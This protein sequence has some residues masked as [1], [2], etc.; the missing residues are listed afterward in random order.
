MADIVSSKPVKRNEPSEQKHPILDKWGLPAPTVEDIFPLM[1]AETELIA[2]T[3]DIYS[4]SEIQEA[5][6]GYISL[7]L[8]R[9]NEN[10][11][12]IMHLG[13]DEGRMKIRLVH[14]SP[15]VLTIEN[16][17][18]AQE[19]LDIKRLATTSTPNVAGDAP[20]QVDSAT[21][22]PM[23]Q[24]KRTSTSWFCYYHTVPV[25]L[26]KV[27]HMLGIN[28]PHMEEPQIVRYQPGQE[29]SWHYDQV[30]EQP[31][32][33]RNGGQRLATLL[34][35]LNTVET[36]GGTV[37][38]DLKQPHNKDGPL[39]VQPVRGSAL[40][41]FPATADGRPDDRTLHKGSPIP[42]CNYNED[43]DSK[44]KWIAQVWIHERP[45]TAAIPPN[46]RQE[47]AHPMVL[48]AC[49]AQGYTSITE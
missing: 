26:A 30:P 47:D 20:V 38:R 3:K 23:A 21:F 2:A 24:S 36:G 29:F 31:Q 44:N 41:F 19:C 1:P 35:Y 34:V 49:R 17:M 33:Q 45:Y 27:K 4:R 13:P 12:E 10:A 39:T 22:S 5:L 43:D 18:T 8:S 28:V 16:F 9:F 14:Q 32:L 15:P 37:F 6:K 40:L 46:N 48:E 25:L 7:D 42:K 11:V